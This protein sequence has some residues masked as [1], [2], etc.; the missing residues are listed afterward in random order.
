MPSPAALESLLTRSSG[1]AVIWLLTLFHPQFGTVRFARNTVNITSRGTEFLR[2][3]FDVGFV[4]D[5]DDLPT[6]QLTVLNVDREIG[7]AI[8]R[9]NTPLIEA[10]LEAVLAS[11]FDDVIRRAARLQLHAVSFNQNVVTGTL[12]HKRLNAEPYPNK[13]IIPSKFPGYYR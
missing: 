1:D 8:M 2:A 6:V 13:R 11:D 3:P 12:S 4:T 7:R 10:N 5:N 9:V